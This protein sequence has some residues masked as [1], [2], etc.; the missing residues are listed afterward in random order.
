MSALSPDA[1]VVAVTR[2]ICFVPRADIHRA[3]GKTPLMKSPII[4]RWGNLSGD[5]L[6]TNTLFGG[7]LSDKA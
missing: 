5:F 4:T 1:N 2:D 3:I 6:P 7:A